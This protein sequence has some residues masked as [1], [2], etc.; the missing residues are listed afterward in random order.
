M[1]EYPTGRR[2]HCRRRER[3]AS[4]NLSTRRGS[5]E[6]LGGLSS[7]VHIAQHL[8]LNPAAAAA[9][10]A[11]VSGY[12]ARFKVLLY[13]F[14]QERALPSYPQPPTPTPSFRTEKHFLSKVVVCFFNENISLERCWSFFS[15][16]FLFPFSFFCLVR[17]TDPD[18]DYIS[19]SRIA[20]MEILR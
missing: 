12:T 1:L 2:R 13:I 15:S 8:G 10:A 20:C 3:I 19:R 5:V 14:V 16:I 6:A 17:L 9:T 18:S 11:S 7:L 4:R